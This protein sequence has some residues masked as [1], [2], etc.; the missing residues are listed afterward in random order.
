[1]MG[2]DFSDDCWITSSVTDSD[3]SAGVSTG[4]SGSLCDGV[5]RGILN[6]MIFSGSA[7]G[8]FAGGGGAF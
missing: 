7:R 2:K 6:I 1:M 5:S 3:D 4:A 8:L